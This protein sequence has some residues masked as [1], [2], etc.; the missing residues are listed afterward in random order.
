MKRF[1]DE[2]KQPKAAMEFNAGH[3]MSSRQ[4]F[5]LSFHSSILFV[6]IS[7]DEKKAQEWNRRSFAT[8][9]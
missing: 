8:P 5:R 9:I 6:L 3:S 7:D 1:P 2:T 4:C